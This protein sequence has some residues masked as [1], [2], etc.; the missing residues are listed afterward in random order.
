MKDDKNWYQIIMTMQELNASIFG[1]AEINQSLNRGY[2][3]K[4]H[5]T[6]RKIFLHSQTAVSES[7]IQ[8]ESKY[9][10]GGTMTIVT[11]KWQA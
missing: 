9:K 5:N 7:N 1:F 10:P 3:S 2:R 4:W 6:L 11:G 8:L